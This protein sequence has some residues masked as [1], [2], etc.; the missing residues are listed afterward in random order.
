VLNKILQSIE[1]NKS[2][3]ERVEI[4]R[5]RFNVDCTKIEITN[6][7]AQCWVLGMQRKIYLFEEKECF[8][9]VSASTSTEPNKSMNESAI[10]NRIESERSISETQ[11]IL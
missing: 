7:G 5:K 1:P 11:V 10:E 9:V 8:I 3:Q 4:F 6:S 2:Y